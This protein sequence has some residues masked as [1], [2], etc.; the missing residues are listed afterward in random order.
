MQKLTRAEEELMQ[1]IWKL[2]KGFLKDIME[3][4]PTPKP[5]QSTVSTILRILE[6]K[7]FVAHKVY[8]KSH[9]YYPLVPKGSYAKAFFQQFLQNY[10]NGSMPSMLSFFHKE[11]DLKMKDLDEMMRT[12]E[13]DT[14]DEN[15]QES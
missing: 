4:I 11:G 1:V 10:F 5:S 15:T 9:E 14:N 7:G 13:L 12:F 3:A 6:K 2:E 8:G